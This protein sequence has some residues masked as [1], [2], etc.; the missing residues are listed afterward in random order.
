MPVEERLNMQTVDVIIPTYK[1]D[2]SFLELIDRLSKQTVAVHRIIIMNTEQK[3]FD[4]LVYGTRFFDQYRNLTVRH[5][6]KWEF[7][8]GATR[9]AGVQHSEADVFVC[10]TQD[11]MPQ[12]AFMLEHLL[13]ALASEKVAVAYGRQ[14][15]RKDCGIVEAYTRDFNYPK[16]GRIKSAA[17]L[18]K[19]GIKTYFCSNVCAA[20]RRSVYD[21]LGGFIRH[22][23]FNEDMIYAAGAVK[24]GYQIAYVPEAMVIHSHP[25]TNGEQFRRNFDL[26]VSQADH[27]EVFAGISSESEGM[28]FV[29]QTVKYLKEQKK[30][31]LIP[32]F[33]IQCGCKYVGYRLGKNYQ[34]LPHSLLIKCSMHKNYWK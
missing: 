22:T 31:G 27:P 23:I 25:Y 16:T 6:S 18:P 4:R 17:D 21:K 2:Q 34:K 30:A 12:D 9:H 29:R 32:G 3:Y 28:S 10:L 1:P 14:L 19:L 15:P 5:L 33:I 7:D 24:A 26:G 11:A 20:Y 13:Q 8:H